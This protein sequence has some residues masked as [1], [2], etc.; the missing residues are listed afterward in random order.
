MENTETTAYHEAGH[1]LIAVHVGADVRSLT[2]DPDADDGPLRFGDTQIEWSVNGLSEREFREHRILVALAG[3][4]AEMLYTG[5]L[6]HPGLVSEW[7]G[8]WREAWDAATLLFPDERQRLTFLEQ[9][10]KELYQL[11]NTPCCWSALAALADELLAHE[12]LEGEQVED[13]V[14]LWLKN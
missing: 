1:A 5:D 11:L 13:I 8:D 3:P 2:I 6:Y 4:V 7:S 9:S 12:T 14:K 10:V